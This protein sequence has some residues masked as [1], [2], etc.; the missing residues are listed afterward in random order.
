MGVHLEGFT[1]KGEAPVQ[2]HDFDMDFT[3]PELRNRALSRRRFQLNGNCERGARVW[4][5]MALG[6]ARLEGKEYEVQDGD[7]ITFRFKV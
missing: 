6:K 2:V 7:I 3:S 1:L 4:Q 5:G